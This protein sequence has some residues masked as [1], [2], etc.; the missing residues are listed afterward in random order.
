M[1]IK[2]RLPNHLLAAL[3][4]R[5]GYRRYLLMIRS[6]IVCVILGLPGLVNADIAISLGI[7][8]TFHGDVGI[9]AKALSSDELDDVVVAAGATFYPF[10]ESKIGFDIGVGR[11]AV[12]NSVFLIG[13]DLS[14]DVSFM[15]VGYVNLSSE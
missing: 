11:I 14:N 5:H 1:S 8:F 4:I 10:S 9:T 13:V 2:C 15:S 12:L 6:F 7:N 3:T